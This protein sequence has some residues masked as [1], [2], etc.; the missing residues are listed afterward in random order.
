MSVDGFFQADEAGEDLEWLCGG[1]FVVHAVAIG[2]LL[3][4][5]LWLLLVVGFGLLFIRHLLL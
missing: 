2:A 5:C 1:F 4:L 3:Q